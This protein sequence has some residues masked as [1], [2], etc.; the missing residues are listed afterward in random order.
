MWR[1]W[2]EGKRIQPQLMRVW[3]QVF[4]WIRMEMCDRVAVALILARMSIGCM[5]F[6]LSLQSK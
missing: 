3:M 4:M 5:C 6:Y 2:G 1:R